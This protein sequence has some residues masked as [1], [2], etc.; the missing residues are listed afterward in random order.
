M[1]N[2][3]RVLSVESQADTDNQ[4]EMK[5]VKGNDMHTVTQE[6]D[7]EVDSNH[8]VQEERCDEFP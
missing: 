1:N 7:M 8:A 3:K 6:W 5:K 2:R 4:T